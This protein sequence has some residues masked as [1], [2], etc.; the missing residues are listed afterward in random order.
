MKDEYYHRKIVMFLVT[1]RW[2]HIRQIVASKNL[3]PPGYNM[4]RTSLL[5]KGCWTPSKEHGEQ[6]VFQLLVVD[7]WMHKEGISLTS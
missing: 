1:A 5:F 6:S 3:I 4:L 2:I 7:R